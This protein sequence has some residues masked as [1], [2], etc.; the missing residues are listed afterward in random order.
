MSTQATKM[1]NEQKVSLG[2]QWLD[3]FDAE[4]QS[5]TKWFDMVNLNRFDMENISICVLAQV[6][7]SYETGKRA[8]EKV[9][10]FGVGDPNHPFADMSKEWKQ[11]ILK[12]RET[13]IAQKIEA[14]RLLTLKQTK[15]TILVVIDG[16]AKLVESFEVIRRGATY[17]DLE[18]FKAGQRHANKG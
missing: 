4:N 1:T 18:L 11:L 6:C 5:V 14:E 12:R 3:K 17:D 2:A 13:Q 10:W 7:G 9:G 8:M 15:P 16:E